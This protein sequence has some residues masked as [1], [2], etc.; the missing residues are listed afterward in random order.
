MMM[1]L[2]DHVSQWPNLLGE[3]VREFPM[4]YRSWHNIKEE[5][6]AGVMGKIESIGLRTLRTG[7]TT[8]KLSDPDVSRSSLRYIGM[9]ISGFG[10]IPRTWPD[11]LK[12]L[13]TGQRAQSCA[14]TDP[15]HLLPSEIGS[16]ETREYPSLIQ[17]FFDTHTGGGVFLRDEDRC[18]Y[19]EMQ[20]L[21]ALGE[22]T[23]D[24]IM[25]I[26]RKGKQRGH[27]P[28][29]GRVLAGRDKDVLDV[30]EPRC[31][32]TF[33]VDELKRNNKQLKKQMDM[34]MKVVRSD[35]KMSQLLTQLQSQH[36]IGSGNG[37]GAGGDDESGDD[38]DADE[39][40][41]THPPKEDYESENKR[42]FDLLV[43]VNPKLKQKSRKK[44]LDL[45]NCV[46]VPGYVATVERFLE[47]EVTGLNRF[48]QPIKVDAS[49]LHA[50]VL[51]H[52]CDH[53]DDILYVDKMVKQTFTTIKNLKLPLVTQEDQ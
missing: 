14:S 13:E 36:D 11:V 27:I 16:S 23:D 51:Q 47:L 20:R 46:S 31:N 49:G 17:S 39:D 43:I 25:V 18:L 4:H 48:G 29:V 34:I 44:G 3:I 42:P 12:M 15:G 30:P 5:R 21:Q 22:Y 1:P 53:L 19:E 2:G 33:D 45:E 9:S 35:D 10:L 24:Q 26:V 50:R 28:G 40:E 7:L 41:D 8:W 52:E 37:S 38:E 32:H 6:K